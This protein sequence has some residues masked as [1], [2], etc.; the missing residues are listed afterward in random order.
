[1]MNILPKTVI[2]DLPRTNLISLG[3]RHQPIR[4]AHHHKA[5]TITT[6]LSLRNPRPYLRYLLPTPPNMS[7]FRAKKLDLGCFV[8]IKVIRD[9]TKR[10]VF[11]QHEQER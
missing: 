2:L 7:M 8:N 1:M 10:K 5:I 6:N 3:T 4:H 9:H 11:E